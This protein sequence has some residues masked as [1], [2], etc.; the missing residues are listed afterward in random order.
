MHPRDTHYT[1]PYWCTPRTS[2]TA[3]T[4]TDIYHAACILVRKSQ[5]IG[6]FSISQNSALSGNRCAL[7]ICS[8]YVQYDMFLVWNR[9][10]VI[11]MMSFL[12]RTIHTSVCQCSCR[13]VAIMWKKTVRAGFA[14]KSVGSGYRWKGLGRQIPGDAYYRALPPPG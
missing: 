8:I 9:K 1:S 13:V 12:I 14:N 7:T 5:Q 6:K 3:H 2:C 11:S 4:H 10:S